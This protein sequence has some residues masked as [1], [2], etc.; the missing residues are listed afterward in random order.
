[1]SVSEQDHAPSWA[2]APSNLSLTNEDAHVWRGWLDRSPAE[3]D[4]FHVLLAAD[5]QERAARFY[6]ERDR[7]R[8]IV[9]RGLL[10]TILARYLGCR[11]QAVRFA[12]GENGKPFLH[13]DHGNG[14][15]QFNM[16]HSRQMALYAIT[17]GRAVGVDVEY[18]RRLADG[19]Q[20]AKRFFSPDEAKLVSGAPDEQQRVFFQIWTRKEA[21]IKAIG[22]GLAQPLA[23][24]EVARPQTGPLPF[25]HLV[26][27][28]KAAERWRIV[29][30]YPH[31]EYAGAL[32][33][34]GEQCRLSQW[35]AG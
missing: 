25:V 31:P 16:T 1:M 22:L 28:P 14:E 30:L 2:P 27:R 4:A 13:P 5:E 9:A 15:L 24:F 3:T 33:V 12:Y 7:R 20:I 19:G 32:V 23:E 10:R 8:F 34:E 35:Q 26:K 29:D 6:F 21:Y 17:Q 18:R 11:P